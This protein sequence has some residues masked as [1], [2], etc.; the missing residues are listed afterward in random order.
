[1]KLFKYSLIA[2]IALS[3]ALTACSDD[4]DFV[5]GKDSP[6]VFFP[7]TDATTVTLP[8]DAASFNVTV[9]RYGVTEAASYPVVATVAEADKGKFTV[10]SAVTFTEGQTSADLVI[11]YNADAI[12][13]DTPVKLT[14]S[15]GEGTQLNVYGNTTLDMTLTIPAP[16]NSLGEAIYI[17]EIVTSIYNFTMSDG[18]AVVSPAWKVELQES[19]ETPGLYRLVNTYT[20]DNSPFGNYAYSDKDVYITIDA[21]NPNK[22]VVPVFSTNLQIEEETGLL[23]GASINSGAQDDDPSLYGVLK[24]NVVSFPANS[25]LAGILAGEKAYVVSNPVN[26]VFPGGVLADYTSAIEWG[27]IFTSAAGESMAVVNV[28]LGDDVETAAVAAVPASVASTADA[29]VEAVIAKTV[30]TMEVTA[31]GTYN[32]PLT[33]GGTY[34]AVVVAYAGGNVQSSDR[35]RFAF[36]AGGGEDV[37]SWE[38]FGRAEFI[39]GWCCAAFN[40]GD[41]KT[42]EDFPWVVP[43]ERNKQNPNL[44]RLVNPYNQPGDNI[45]SYNDFNADKSTNYVVIDVTDPEYIIIEPQYSGLTWTDPTGNFPYAGKEWYIGNVA[46]F[47]QSTGAAT[48]EQVVDK[49]LNDVMTDGEIIINLPLFG[50]DGEFGYNWKSEPYSMIWIENLASAA[51]GPAKVANRTRRAISRIMGVSTRAERPA[52]RACYM[53]A[54]P[55]AGK[56]K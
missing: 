45:V 32:L 37:G 51:E 33:E 52:V 56:I 48:K 54:T 38:D 4:D 11:G 50:Y 55:Y 18:S 7:S 46:G 26:I 17:D 3:G 12:G 43:V 23:V 8:R 20:C 6:G 19:A 1:M 22:V 31:S 15:F 42:Y 30:E 25:F 27:G 41:G 34:Y 47:Y 28:T 35:A 2:A 16:W 10:P 39:D 13:Y 5:V 9:S 40:Y 29:A 24:D 14:L 21:R 49:G 53:S 44:I 36:N